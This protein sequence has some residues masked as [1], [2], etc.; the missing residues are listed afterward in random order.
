[1]SPEM[2]AFDAWM[3]V[4]HPKEFELPA[5]PDPDFEAMFRESAAAMKRWSW[6]EQLTLGKAL[7]VFYRQH[8]DTGGF[9]AP[10]DPKQPT[11]S[12]LS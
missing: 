6:A 9:G 2:R 8:P 12:L 4:L 10:Y 1:M 7:T 5:D 3:H 11:T